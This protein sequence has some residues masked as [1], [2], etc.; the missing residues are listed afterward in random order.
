MSER[1]A[2]LTAKLDAALDALQPEKRRSPT[3]RK[4]LSRRAKIV[5]AKERGS[6]W[7]QLAELLTK[8]GMPVTASNLQKIIAPE[9]AKVTA[10]VSTTREPKTPR[11]RRPPPPPPPPFDP[12]GESR[13]DPP[14]PPPPA[15]DWLTDEDLARV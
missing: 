14:P 13:D 11:K 12:A 15:G 8:H 6:T 1:D 9:I 2:A 4:I 10:K 7:P 5:A 3:V